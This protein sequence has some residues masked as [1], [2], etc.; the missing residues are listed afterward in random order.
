MSAID[1]QGWKPTACILCE[2]NCGIEVQL[3][4]E[5]GRQLVRFR[6]DKRHPASRG[7]PCERPQRLDYYQN[8]PDRLL[9]PLRRRPDG[10][11]EEVD[12]D[13]VIPVIDPRR[14][15]TAELADI[16]LQLRPVGRGAGPNRRAGPQ[17]P[18]RSA[19]SVGR[20][21]QAQRRP[22]ARRRCF[23]LRPGRR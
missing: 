8:A 3:G 5:D 14:T 2:R 13:T 22:R 10:S 4:G 9:R 15:K 7:Y 23:P 18:A 20:G 19:G 6:G 21:R 11:F 16:H 17:E 12:W 1:N